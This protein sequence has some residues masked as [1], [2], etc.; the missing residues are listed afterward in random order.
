MMKFTRMLAIA[1]VLSSGHAQAQS[2][3]WRDSSGRPVPE[4]DSMKS[5][6]GFAGSLLATTDKNWEKKWNTPPETK[7]HFDTADVVPYGKKIFILTLFSNPKRDG[8]GYVNVR[9]DIKLIDPRGKASL[10]QQDSTCYA[11]R[12]GGNPYNV[13]LCAPVVGFSGDPGDPAGVWI[14]EVKLRDAIRNVDLRLRTTFTLRKSV[15]VLPD[16]MVNRAVRK[17]M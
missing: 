10:I 4:T 9:C 17:G 3:Y 12:L 8:S 16:H 14:V 15:A 5:K 1:T 2:G 13:Y 7:P 6:D 11:G